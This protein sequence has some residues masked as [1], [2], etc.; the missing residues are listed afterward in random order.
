MNHL[1]SFLA[2]FTLTF[3]FKIQAFILNSGLAEKC[4]GA[5]QDMNWES[6]W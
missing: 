3:P 5:V 6:Q 2:K 4:L 1:Y